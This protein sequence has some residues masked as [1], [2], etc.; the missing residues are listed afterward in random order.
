MSDGRIAIRRFTGAAVE[1][2]RAEMITAAMCELGPAGGDFVVLRATP[3]FAEVIERGLVS[4]LF[5]YGAH[6]VGEP[7]RP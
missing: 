7:V 6:V 5:T 3:E 2:C 1:D 4:Q